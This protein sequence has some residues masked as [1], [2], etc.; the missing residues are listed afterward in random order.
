MRTRQEAVMTAETIPA[1]DFEARLRAVYDERSRALQ[2][3]SA[4]LGHAT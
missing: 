2:Q 4:G 3:F 1:S